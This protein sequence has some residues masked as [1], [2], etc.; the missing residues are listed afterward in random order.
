MQPVPS[1]LGALALAAIVCASAV[2][3]A[4]VYSQNFDVDDTA[5]WTVNNNAIGN[6]AA[7]IFFDYST[8]GIPAG[9]EFRRHD[10]G[11]QSAG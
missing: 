7:N 10:A 3:A 4:P 9:A 6:N 5:N 2:S 8:I 11:A 1:A